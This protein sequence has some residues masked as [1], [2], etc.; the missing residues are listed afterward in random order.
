MVGSNVRYQTKK[1]YPQSRNELVIETR[2]YGAKVGCDVGYGVGSLVGPRE[3]TRDGAEVGTVGTGVGARV[4]GTGVGSAVGGLVYSTTVCLVSV[5]DPTVA[6]APADMLNPVEFA[7]ASSSAS[8][9]LPLEAAPDIS[10][11]NCDVRF[12]A[13]PS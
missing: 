6:L 13:L 5:V 12:E 2:I 4:V 9:R 11:E 3:G 8:V 10:E 1:T 7:L